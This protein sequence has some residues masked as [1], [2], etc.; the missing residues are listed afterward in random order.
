LTEC[1]GSGKRKKLTFKAIAD[2]LEAQGYKAPRGGLLE[3]ESV[4]SI[5]KKSLER[6]KRLNA[7]PRKEIRKFEVSAYDKVRLHQLGLQVG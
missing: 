1:T 4:F 2:A 3:A 7:F 5:Y 6:L